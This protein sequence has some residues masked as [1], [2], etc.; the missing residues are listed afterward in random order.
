VPFRRVEF[1]SAGMVQ[2][3]GDPA[4]KMIYIPQAWNIMNTG[5]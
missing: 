5:M 3:T 2:E 1:L 4:G